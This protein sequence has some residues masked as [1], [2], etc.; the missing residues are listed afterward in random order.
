ML[1]QIL[2]VVLNNYD[3][4]IEDGRFQAIP[5][6][7]HAYKGALLAHFQAILAAYACYIRPLVCL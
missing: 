3:S 6:G 5:K 4:P 2:M 7:C 1:Y